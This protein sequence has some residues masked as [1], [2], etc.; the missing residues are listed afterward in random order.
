MLKSSKP[1]TFEQDETTIQQ[2][3]NSAI[4]KCARREMNPEQV[5]SIYK[6]GS[7]TLQDGRKFRGLVQFDVSVRILQEG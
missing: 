4:R 7:G 2:M 1:Y 6:Y 5:I 3:A